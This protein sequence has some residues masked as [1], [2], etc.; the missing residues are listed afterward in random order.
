QSKEIL[1]QFEIPVTSEYTVESTES[2]I[3]AAEQLGFPVV[4][5]GEHPALMHKSDLGLV[6]LN[7]HTVQQVEKAYFELEKTMTEAGY[8]DAKVAVQPMIDA[9]V[10]L[11][12]GVN[13]DPEFGPVVVLGL[14]GVFVEVLQDVVMRVAPFDRQIALEMINSLRG[15]RLLEG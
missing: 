11:I 7:L 15:V 14:G 9:G 13:H 6:K 5:K 2:A 4:L 3:V 10:E 8:Q 12:L 1:A